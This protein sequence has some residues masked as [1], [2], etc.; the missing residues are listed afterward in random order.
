M[1]YTFH[2][3][4]LFLYYYINYMGRIDS[5]GTKIKILYF[6]IVNYGLATNNISVIGGNFSSYKNNNQ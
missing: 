5:Y 2:K 3:R 1:Y 4:F 6:L